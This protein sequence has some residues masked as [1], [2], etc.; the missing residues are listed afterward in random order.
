MLKGLPL[1][2]SDFRSL[3]ANNEIY[4]DKT[5]LIHDMV[6]PSQRR[7]LLLVRPRRFGKSLLISTFESLFKNGL[8]DFKGLAIEKYWCYKEY[9]VVR[10]DLSEIKEFSTADE[11]EQKFYEKL[12]TK[13][14]GV[15]FQYKNNGLLLMTQLSEWLS[16]LEPSCLVILIDEYDAPL[17][18]CL[19][20][21]NLFKEVRSAMSELFLTLKSNEGCLRFFFMTGITKLSNTSIFSAFNNLEDISLYPKYGTLLGYTEEEI[22]LY[23]KDYLSRAAAQLD[24]AEDQILEQL[25]ANYDG[26][27]F[28]QNASSHVYCPWSVL[29][30]FNYP[31]LGYQNYWYASGGQ[32]SVLKKHLMNHELEK[33]ISF[34]QVKQVRLSELNAAPQYN[35]LSIDIL[36][37]QSGY[38][39]IKSVLKN[40]YAVLGYPNQEVALSMAQLYSDELLKGNQLEDPQGPMI[41]DIMATGS[42]EE[43][44]K[45]FNRAVNAIDY[46]R[47]P[48]I[49]EASCRAYLQI[50]LIGAAMMP[51]VE[52]HNAHGRSDMEVQSGSRHWVFEFKYASTDSE[53]ETLL[54]KAIEQIR[55]QHY[56][57]QVLDKKLIRV[58]LVFNAKERQFTAWQIV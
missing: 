30:F 39:T 17:T 38:L 35:D 12:I 44:V 14:S 4:V 16:L 2:S 1:G 20:Q 25:R 3:R 7:K 45:A 6:E 32:P 50:L 40:G 42:T 37:T 55:S 29:K 21:P 31:E 52:I 48:I 13:F 43:V 34:D 46:Q 54:T 53:V 18:N 24:M 28:D 56:G 9:Q 22:K 49:D 47:Y 5:A 26:F 10:L 41:S 15:G 19:D 11:F 36:L 51:S 58:A 8:K 27:S 33:P 57:E 23:F